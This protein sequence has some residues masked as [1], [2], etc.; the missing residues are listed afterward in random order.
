MF[1]DQF[2]ALCRVPISHD[3]HDDHKT[4]MKESVIKGKTKI[5]NKSRLY[6][7]GYKLAIRK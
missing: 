1:P 7:L 2:V 5:A 4:N 3:H 6:K